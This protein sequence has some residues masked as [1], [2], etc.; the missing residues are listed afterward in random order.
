MPHYT[1]TE[2][3]T[4]LSIGTVV[5]YLRERGLLEPGLE[6]TPSSLG[7]GVSNVVL[8]VRS[9][10]RG[11]VVKQ[12][13]PALRVAEH[14]PAKRE[15]V[16][17]EAA[18]LQW[19]YGV[20]P[21]AVPAV[22]DVDAEH[23]T[24]SIALAPTEWQNWKDLLL[25][26]QAEPQVAARLGSILG[27]WHNVS[28]D[29]MDP[30]LDDAEAFEQL[31]VDPYYR[32]VMRRH[33]DHAPSIGYYVERML[34]THSCLVHGDCSPKNVLVGDDGL[35]LLDFEVAHLGDPAFDLAFMINHL[36]LKAIHRP[37]ASHAFE[38]CAHAFWSAYITAV[39]EGFAGE[40]SYILGHT[41]CLMLARV[42]GKSPAEYLTEPERLAARELGSAL[43]HEPPAT[44]ADGWERARQAIDQ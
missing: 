12:S 1:A 32:T 24:I 10:N 15:R 42:D 26:G 20:T 44:L 34:T 7:G 9:G 16:I 37:A 29:G 36:L 5:E 14:W 11:I 2:P 27:A 22:L 13:L 19:A 25:T 43:L 30:R 33:P 3:G 41:G 4:L 21:N 18:A 35:W 38:Q 6:V 31:R 8:A 17:T 23:Y 40:T 39:P 28:R